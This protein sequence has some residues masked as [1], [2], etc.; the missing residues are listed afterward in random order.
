MPSQNCS[1]IYGTRSFCT[2]KSPYCFRVIRIHIHCFCSIAPAR[3]DCNGS[4]Y[5]FTLKFFG[6]SCA[7]SHTTNSRIRNDTFHRTTVTV[8]QIRRNKFCYGFGQIHSLFFKAFTH[9]TLTSVYSGT[10][11]NFRVIFHVSI[12]Y[13]VN[14]ICFLFKPGKFIHAELC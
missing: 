8:S 11:P 10:N 12:I 4:S 13:K 9:A 3:S 1:Q 2:I 7:F 6:T 14:V 5:A